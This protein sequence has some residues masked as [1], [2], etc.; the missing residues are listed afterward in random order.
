MAKQRVNVEITGTDRTRA[1]FAGVRA[2][3]DH[4]NDTVERLGKSTSHVDRLVRVLRS[5]YL[6]FLAL[7]MGFRGLIGL[8]KTRI[9]MQRL[10][11]T[12]LAATGSMQQAGISMQFVRRVSDK[13]GLS[14]TTA[15]DGLSQLEAAARGSNVSLKEARDLW[16]SVSKATVLYHLN[17]DR[18]K[19]VMYSLIEMMSEGRIQSRQLRRQLA[20][21]LPVGIV[22]RFAHQIAIA[23]HN[24]AFSVHDLNKMMKKGLITSAK[25][26]PLLGKAI[27]AAVPLAPLREATHSFLSNVKR[28][29]NSWLDLQRTI[30]KAGFITGVSDLIK[31]FIAATKFMMTNLTGIGEALHTLF[32]SLIGIIGV[33]FVQ[34]LMKAGAA[35]RWLGRAIIELKS[36]L[37]LIGGPAGVIMLAVVAFASFIYYASKSASEAAALEGNIKGLTKAFEKLNLAQMQLHLTTSEKKLSSLQAN[38]AAGPAWL[39]KYNEQFSLAYGMT[40]KAIALADKKMKTEMNKQESWLIAKIKAEKTRIAQ[41]KNPQFAGDRSGKPLIPVA[42]PVLGNAKGA[43]ALASQ[44]KQV[45]TSIQTPLQKYNATL[46]RLHVLLK[47]AYI[48]Q[49]QFNLAAEKAMTALGDARAGAQSAMHAMS[50][51]AIQAAR[52]MQTSFADFLFD[53]FAG[54]L[55]GMVRGFAT[56]LRRMMANALAARLSRALFG[57]MGSAVGGGAASGLVSKGV[58]YGVNYLKLVLMHSGGIVGRNGTPGMAPAALFASAPRLHTGGLIGADEVPAILQ[59]GEEIL[60]ANDPRHRANVK[61]QAINIT[62]NVQTT[63]AASFRRSEQQ[64]GLRLGETIRRAMGRD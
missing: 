9:E 57:G 38:I 26:L 6:S 27:T 48:N 34:A 52:S 12:F 18:V 8:T 16:L 54:G 55:K 7:R 50:Q 33:R 44:A 4:L 56:A 3:L 42:P 23:T 29:K 20:L 43:A 46:A 41:L 61:P 17:T 49:T 35:T 51:Y 53:P 25:Y 60:T 59:R 39:K 36:T 37:K 5:N 11:F 28:M 10:K 31:G 45:I 19:R 32:F 58:A 63:D 64:V 14:F 1:A 40:P 13:L 24:A 30:N 21:A 15:A 47:G 2:G 22:T 62:V